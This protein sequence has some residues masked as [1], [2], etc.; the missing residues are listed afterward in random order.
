ML[1][2]KE[3]KSLNVRSRLA[4]VLIDW[5]SH[6]DKFF[7]GCLVFFI[8]REIFS[9]PAFINYPFFLSVSRNEILQSFDGNTLICNRLI[10][11]AS[12]SGVSFSFPR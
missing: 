6:S 9:S 1:A 7:V 8:N 4:W 12:A 11:I 2:L 10:I 5:F 3:S